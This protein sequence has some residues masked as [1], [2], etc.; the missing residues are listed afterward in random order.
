[1]K[2]L[3]HNS[4]FL[5]QCNRVKMGTAFTNR[6]PVHDTSDTNKMTSISTNA[7]QKLML[8]SVSQISQAYPIKTEVCD[9]A[10]K[11]EKSIRRPLRRLNSANE[12]IS[13]AKELE[14]KAKQYK[15]QN[16]RNFK[17]VDRNIRYG[18]QFIPSKF[19]KE[20]VFFL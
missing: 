1:M 4:D 20:S 12:A 14:Q 8:S 7:N 19:K 11:A 2:I 6:S 3:F 16:E 9:E 5:D 13:R 18:V 17:H 10:F 15:T